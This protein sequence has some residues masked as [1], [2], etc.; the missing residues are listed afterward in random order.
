MPVTEYIAT[1]EANISDDSFAKAYCFALDSPISDAVVLT[2]IQNG[3]WATSD[4]FELMTPDI[5]N[6]NQIV[7][8]SAAL[9]RFFS[10]SMDSTD[11]FLFNVDHDYYVYVYAIDE[12]L[13]DVVKSYA[14]NPIN[15]MDLKYNIVVTFDEL[16]FGLTNEYVQPRASPEDPRV[17]YNDNDDMFGYVSNKVNWDTS[18]YITT[19]VEPKDSIITELYIMAFE[20]NYGNIVDKTMEANMIQLATQHSI[21]TQVD[22]N[23]TTHGHVFIQNEIS[24]KEL[25]TFFSTSDITTT[26]LKSMT[27]GTDYYLYSCIYDKS[28]DRYIIQFE[29]KVKAGFYPIIEDVSASGYNTSELG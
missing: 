18:L 25:S 28:F 21:H 24:N 20:E 12:H 26:E 3:Q 6:T 13:N 8:T 27:L 11:S 9:K 2:A 29:K 7:K 22:L 14:L 19:T 4:Q 15:F 5:P 10:A 17:D 23:S 1:I 16:L